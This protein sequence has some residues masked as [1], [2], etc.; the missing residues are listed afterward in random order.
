MP[1]F[2][3]R[4]VEILIV[5]PVCV[6]RV[7]CVRNRRTSQCCSTGYLLCQF[8]FVCMLF[9]QEYV[10]QLSIQ[11]QIRTPRS[12]LKM[13]WNCHF[14]SV[15]MFLIVFSVISSHTIRIRALVS[16]T[17]LISSACQVAQTFYTTKITRLSVLIKLKHFTYL[18][19]FCFHSCFQVFNTKMFKKK[20]SNAAHCIQPKRIR[21]SPAYE[22]KTEMMPFESMKK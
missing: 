18:F 5:P 12:M 8:W 20:C 11:F 1:I 6:A 14:P 10:F 9:S 21:T 19:P 7:L 15:T 13:S 16:G 3:I 2:S 22:V 4:I 17:I